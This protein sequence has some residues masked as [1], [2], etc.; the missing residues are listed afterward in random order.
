MRG[1][2]DVGG[3]PDGQGGGVLLRQVRGRPLREQQAQLHAGAATQVG[4]LHTQ[5]ESGE[6]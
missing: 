6:I 1:P 3:E 5:V 2:R 4:A